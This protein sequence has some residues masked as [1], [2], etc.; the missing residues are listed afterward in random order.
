MKGFISSSASQN[1]KI[2]G[3]VSPTAAG[4][5]TTLSTSR[6]GRSNSTRIKWVYHTPTLKKGTWHLYK[7]FDKILKGSPRKI[8]LRTKL[9]TNPRELLAIHMIDT[10]NIWR[11]K[12]WYKTSLLL[13][14]VSQILTPCLV[15]TL[16]LPG[17]V[18][19]ERIR[20]GWWCITLLHLRVFETTQVCESR[21]RCD[22]CE[23]RA[24][25]DFTVTWYK[26]CNCQTQTNPYG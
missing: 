23:R 25:I 1:L 7:S 11:E 26:V 22:F 15:Q 3:S 2:W 4:T 17:E 8:S 12:T 9:I 21:G 6:M 16:L 13:P 18:K 24:I 19:L 20:I 10:L 5:N 14:L